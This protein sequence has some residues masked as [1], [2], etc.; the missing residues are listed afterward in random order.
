VEW[1]I[2]LHPIWQGFIATCF[3]FLMTSA[4]ASLVFFTKKDTNKRMLS[5]M[6]SASA[7]IMLS[8]AFLSLLMPAIKLSPEVGLIDWVAVSVGFLF[9]GLFIMMCDLLSP[10][11][12][13]QSILL[14][15]AVTLHNIPEGLAVGVAF[16]SV[17]VGVPGAT[18]TG[19]IALAFGIALQN[20]PEGLCVSMPLAL[21]G[22]GRT[23]SFFIGQSS[24]LVEPIS[25]VLGVIFALTVRTALPF[26]LSFAGG[27]M[28]IVV[29]AELVPS[30][31]QEYKKTTTA[32]CILGFV[33]MMILDIAL[34]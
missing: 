31:G 30:F 9:G 14:T 33:L 2:S 26:A 29:V 22:T 17:A 28:I 24:G 8:A 10:K 18:I 11:N 23:K 12:R 25:G 7:G 34:G 20:F 32:G 16:G 13:K 15:L 3:C 6:L 1:F 4:G 19:A 21:S 27:A 5:F